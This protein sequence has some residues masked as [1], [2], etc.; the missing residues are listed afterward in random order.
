MLAGAI[1]TPRQ[2]GLS[3]LT[4]L[5][6]GIVGAPVFAGGSAGFGVLAGPTGGYL[7]GFVLGA[8]TIALF[9]GNNHL[10]RL[11]P[12]VLFGGLIVVYIPGTIWLSQVTGLDIKAAVSIGVLPY[13]P[14][15]IFKAVI[16]IA[17]TTKLRVPLQRL[18]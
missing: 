12:A 10:G 5:L 4:F 11:I 2:A 6:L 16:V 14:G 3:M 8:V 9:R 15:D 18:G 17:A 13:L 1:L 7:V